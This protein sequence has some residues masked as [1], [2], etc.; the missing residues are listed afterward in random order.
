MTF[1]SNEDLISQCTDYCQHVGLPFSGVEDASDCQCSAG[2]AAGAIQVSLD[3]CNATCPLGPGAGNEYCGG[4]QRL[5]T[6]T[7]SP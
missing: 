2:F 7:Y 1:A 4:Y 5:E 6:Y 3:E